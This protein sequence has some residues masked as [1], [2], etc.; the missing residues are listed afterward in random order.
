MLC[1]RPNKFLL[2][3]GKESSNNL[4]ISYTTGSQVS[5]P[6]RVEEIGERWVNLCVVLSPLSGKVS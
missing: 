2:P 4:E 6:P 1:S 3:L 5:R